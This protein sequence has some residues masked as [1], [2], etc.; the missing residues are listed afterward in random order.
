MRGTFVYPQFDPERA[1]YM[2][3]MCHECFVERRYTLPHEGEEKAFCTPECCVGYD[4]GVVGRDCETDE[5]KNATLASYRE[6][7]K[8]Y[9]VPAPKAVFLGKGGKREQWLWNHCRHPSRLSWPADIKRANE[10]L[11]TAQSAGLRPADW[12]KD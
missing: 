10:E 2:C 9:V 11:Q 7:F 8:R 6:H 5:E 4:W 1:E 12:A 3:D